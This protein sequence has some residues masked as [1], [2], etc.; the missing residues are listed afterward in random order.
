M[1]SV[2]KEQGE[3]LVPGCR[4]IGLDPAVG[5]VGPLAYVEP[6]L[7]PFVDIE[8]GKGTK[9]L[10]HNLALIGSLGVELGSRMAYDTLV[11]GTFAFLQKGGSLCVRGQYE[12]ATQKAKQENCQ[13]MHGN[14]LRKKK[15]TKT[16]SF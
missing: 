15:N 1:R 12:S 8:G 2:G 9:P 13:A 11:Q 7:A 6:A 14:P 5:L 4:E 3:G 10:V 16:K